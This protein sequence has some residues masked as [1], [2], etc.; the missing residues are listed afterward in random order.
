MDVPLITEIRLLPE[1]EK[2]E[3]ES[4]HWHMAKYSLREGV[5]RTPKL[6]L[7]YYA[8]R[9]RMVL[10]P[11]EIRNSLVTELDV[12]YGSN[13]PWPGF[14]RLTPPTTIEQGDRM[15]QVSLTYRKGVY[16]Q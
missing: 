8:E 3:P 13:Q 12:L 9:E 15:Q 5:M 11:E 2:P 1:G 10:S 14:Q 16:S 6:F 7:W 4:E